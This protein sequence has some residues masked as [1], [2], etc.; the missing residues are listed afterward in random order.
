MKNF[1][2]LFV[3]ILAVSSALAVIDPPG[4][5][6]NPLT[7]D[8][9]I[10]AVVIN[11]FCITP[12]STTHYLAPLFIGAER[13]Y[14]PDNTQPGEGLFVFTVEKE[15]GYDVH[16]STSGCNYSSE[17]EVELQGQW[18]WASEEPTHINSLDQDPIHIAKLF[19]VG[20]GWGPSYPNS[21][22]DP[23]LDPTA[24]GN[25]NNSGNDLVGLHDS[26]GLVKCWAWLKVLKLSAKAI[27]VDDEHP[28]F[29]LQS[30]KITVSGSYENL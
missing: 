10:T 30:F 1:I 18:F 3:F 11:P 7:D 24:S 15:Q 22:N 29:K 2:A 4:S 12:T 5:V 27:V 25:W 6:S 20:W 28:F 9:V 13:V 14:T 8:A 17:N 19:N 23:L 21:D 16:F 26:H